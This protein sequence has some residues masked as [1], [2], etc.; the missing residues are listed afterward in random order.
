MVDFYKEGRRR[1]VAVDTKSG[2]Q[3]GYLEMDH[4]EY[5]GLSV[6]E[7]EKMGKELLRSAQAAKAAKNGEYEIEDDKFRDAYP[8]CFEFVS[9]NT[10]ADGKPRERSKVSVFVD[11]GRWKA[12]L[13]DPTAKASLYVTL[14]GLGTLWDTLELALREP[15]PD[16]RGWKGKR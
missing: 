9:S 7:C 15:K 6:E 11:G 1:I 10:D 4:L 5:Q 12:C 13:T 16:W 2:E 3:L 14:D 8:Y